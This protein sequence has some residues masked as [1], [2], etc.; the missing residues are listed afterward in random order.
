MN[1][2]N[3]KWV[4]KHRRGMSSIRKGAIMWKGRG[5]SSN[6]KKQP[7][8]MKEDKK[9]RN[10]ALSVFFIIPQRFT[11]KI[12]VFFWNWVQNLEKNLRGGVRTNS[13]E[14]EDGKIGKDGKIE[15]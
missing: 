3:K 2:R 10:I 7:P 4:E 13:R 5:M 15:K 8:E 1:R 6:I 14:V 12:F 11:N 9:K